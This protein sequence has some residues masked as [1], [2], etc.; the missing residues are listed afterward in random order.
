[1]FWIVLIGTLVIGFWAQ[2]KVKRCF[3]HYSQIRAHNGY[4][5]GDVAAQI[6]RSAGIHDVGIHVQRGQL[7]DH[8]DPIRKRLVLSDQNYHGT[9]ISAIA[10]AAHECGHAL[11][12]QQSYGPLKFRMASVGITSFAN[13]MLTWIMIGGLFLG[14]IPF[15]IALPILALCWG[16]IM[17]FNL[18]TLP[19]EF[20]ASRRAKVVLNQM[21][22]TSTSTEDEGVS[23]VL[24][25]AAFTY[26][27]AFISSLGWFLYYILPFVT[28]GSDD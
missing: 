5:G 17:A 27:A 14:L 11:Q 6:L 28:G 3:A 19:V 4:S 23:K 1:M 12:H 9:S 15:Q 21:G 7:N 25:A 2:A 26:V 18:V 8:Y 16:V 13:G 10:V 20:D 24:N 22:F